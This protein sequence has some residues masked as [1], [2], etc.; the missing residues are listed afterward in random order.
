MPAYVLVFVLL[1][2]YDATAGCSALR[3]VFGD[4]FSLPEIRTTV[5]TIAV[6][7]LVLYPYVYVLGRAAFLAQ[8]REIARGGADARAQPRGARSGAS[9][10][11]SRGRRWLPASRWR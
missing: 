10:C 2:Q 11:R 8:S 5:G 7:T 6:L 9:R 4:G 3:E 1:G